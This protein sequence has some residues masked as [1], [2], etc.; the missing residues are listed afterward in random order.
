MSAVDA[1]SGHVDDLTSLSELW[2]EETPRVSKQEVGIYA[3]NP[4]QNESDWVSSCI[5]VCFCKKKKSLNLL[6]KVIYLFIH[7]CIKSVSSR[8]H[9]WSVLRCFLFFFASLYFLVSSAAGFTVR[10]TGRVWGC[11][12]ECN[13]GGGRRC[14]CWRSPLAALNLS[15]CAVCPD[16]GQRRDEATPHRQGEP[17]GVRR[18][19]GNAPCRST[20]STGQYRTA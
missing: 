15:P 17:G 11:S 8:K 4:P 20:S 1:A 6:L 13:R 9:R 3:E 16:A 19:G 7:H 12:R 18:Q 10:V 2:V 5:W 14:Q